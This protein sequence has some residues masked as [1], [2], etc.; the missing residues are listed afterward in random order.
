MKENI[1]AFERGHLL[2][3]ALIIASM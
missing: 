1:K 2:Y 3:L